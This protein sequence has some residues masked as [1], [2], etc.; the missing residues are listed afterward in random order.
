MELIKITQKDIDNETER[1][2]KALSNSTFEAF[3]DSFCYDNLEINKNIKITK[4]YDTS[5]SFIL[6]LPC[7][8]KFLAS[9]MTDLDGVWYDVETV[10]WND[11]VLNDDDKQTY[12]YYTAEIEAIY[13][14]LND[15]EEEIM[16]DDLN[17]NNEYIT[18]IFVDKAIIRDLIQHH[19]KDYL[20]KIDVELLIDFIVDGI[21]DLDKWIVNSIKSY[22][23]SDDFY[24]WLDEIEYY[25]ID[26][27]MSEIKNNGFCE[28]YI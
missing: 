10:I 24:N 18:N 14:L 11:I 9:F 16:N 23:E 5:K 25:Q 1:Y 7:D 2:F 15:I 4:V 20:N 6:D 8:E 21:K 17:I 12:N 27:I 28:M 26:Y 3:K 22:F 19:L 13:L